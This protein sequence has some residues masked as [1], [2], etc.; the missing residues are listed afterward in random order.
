M[1]RRKML[2]LIQLAC[3]YHIQQQLQ[4]PTHSPTFCFNVLQV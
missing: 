1:I 4:I 2:Q 3:S